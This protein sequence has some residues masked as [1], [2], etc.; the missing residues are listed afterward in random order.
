VKYN[1][2]TKRLNCETHRKYLYGDNAKDV[3]E[4]IHKEISEKNIRGKYE[5]IVE[6]IEEI[7]KSDEKKA[8][9]QLIYRNNRNENS[10]WF[11]I[12][13]EYVR[14]GMD[15]QRKRHGR[16]DII[17][18]SKKNPHKVAIIEL[19]Y[20]A[21]AMG[22]PSGIRKHAEDF[23]KFIKNDVYNKRFKKEIVDIVNSLN[24]LGIT[25]LR[26]E[27]N[28]LEKKPEF[29]FI[30]L[31]SNEKV[32]DA[33]RYYALKAGITGP[34]SKEFTPRFLFSGNVVDSITIDDII[35]SKEYTRGL[36]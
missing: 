6:N 32:K 19:K 23:K 15:E 1:K 35:E 18:I 27:E 17:A 4:K 30:T 16:F 11:C 8:Q 21:S 14:P 10:K 13:I 12:D 28:K 5:T 20:G 29:Y 9:Q 2:R 36:P 22:E 24:E 7:Y 3:C 33:M 31:A 26:L 34:N 25:G